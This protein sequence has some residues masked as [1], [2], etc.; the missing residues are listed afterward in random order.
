MA[1]LLC[2][3]A[4]VVLILHFFV[5]PSLAE[6][7]KP[8]AHALVL[9]PGPMTGVGSGGPLWYWRLCSPSSVGLHDWEMRYVERQLKPT[10]EQQALLQ[11]LAQSSTEAKRVIAA[12]CPRETI[13]TGLA[14]LAAMERRTAGLFKAVKTVRPAY[15]S[16]YA[17]LTN[18]QKGI[19]D[20]LGPGRTGWRW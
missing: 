20:A 6:N 19:L 10:A 15:E 13:K 2:R 9:L 17:S 4:I 12:A 8:P 1:K 3:F 16:F 11:A 18:R 7:A 14:H 5:L